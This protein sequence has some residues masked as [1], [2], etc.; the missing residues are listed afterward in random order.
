MEF[1][2]LALAEFIFQLFA[3]NIQ[4]FRDELD[5]LR[6]AEKEENQRR[7]QQEEINSLGLIS[8]MGYKDLLW[9][10][11]DI[12]NHIAGQPLEVQLALIDVAPRVAKL[13]KTYYRLALQKKDL[14]QF[15]DKSDEKNLFKM[16]EELK[17]NLTEPKPDPVLQ[18]DR[19]RL[20][21]LEARLDRVTLVRDQIPILDSQLETLKESLLLIRD[22]VLAPSGVVKV[23]VDV[24]EILR[25]VGENTGL[26]DITAALADVED[27]ELEIKTYK[28][29]LEDL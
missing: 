28:E 1:I 11:W 16:C 9:V 21:L 2:L 6:K 19:K 23:R 3:P 5:G 26:E 15:L 25:S 29:A 12:R 7:N 10:Q 22:Q 17:R 20:A 14:L 13:V 18:M 24:D 27:T 8:G 4:F